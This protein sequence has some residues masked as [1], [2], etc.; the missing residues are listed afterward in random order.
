MLPSR[1]TSRFHGFTIVELLIVIVVIGILVSIVTVN[2]TG[3]QA[4]SR[5]AKRLSDAKAI[6]AALE[7]YRSENNGYPAASTATQLAGASTGGWE[8]SGAA[9]PGTFMSALKPYGLTSGVPLDPTNNTLNNVGKIYR[10]KTYAAGTNGCNASS[11]DYYVFVVNDLET[12]SGTSP[13]SPGFSCSGNDW[14]AYGDYV[15]G[16]F[17]NE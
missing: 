13:Q 7:S 12:V 4:R 1:A 10:Y 2:W 8:T 3:A 14:Q 11:G 17:V 9:Q 16:H 15:F 5:D 6:E